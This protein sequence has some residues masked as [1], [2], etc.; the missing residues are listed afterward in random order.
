MM[1]CDRRSSFIIECLSS[2]YNT[3]FAQVHRV[4]SNTKNSKTFCIDNLSR[5]QLETVWIIYIRYSFY[6]KTEVFESLLL[7][8]SLHIGTHKNNVL[9]FFIL[10]F[11][12]NTIFVSS[13]MYP[14][15][16]KDPSNRR[17]NEHGIYI[18]HCQE[19]NSQPVPSQAGVDTTRPQ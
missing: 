2:S 15:N 11:F 6:L 18:R 12:L 8:I 16:P 3:K 5:F 9:F 4:Q 7:G 13:H 19:S 17:L 10:F 14:E 1:F